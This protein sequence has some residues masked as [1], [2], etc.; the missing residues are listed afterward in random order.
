MGSSEIQYCFN[1]AQRIFK[2]WK[3]WPHRDPIPLLP[4]LEGGK[5]QGCGSTLKLS[6]QK[7]NW[8]SYHG[9]YNTGLPDYWYLLVK[10]SNNKFGLPYF[11]EDECPV[12]NARVIVSEMKYPNGTSDQKI[13][14]QLCG[15]LSITI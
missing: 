11:A 12:C 9:E 6:S 5:C 13:N 3:G 15:V 10:E 14:C 1:C 4:L 2:G 7:I 8:A